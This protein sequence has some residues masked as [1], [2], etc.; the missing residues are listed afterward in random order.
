MVRRNIETGLGVGPPSL[1]TAEC[2][3]LDV[4]VELSQVLDQVAHE[5]ARRRF[6]RRRIH[7]REAEHFHR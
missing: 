2:E 1:T 3:Y 5:A 4:H 6:R 7:V